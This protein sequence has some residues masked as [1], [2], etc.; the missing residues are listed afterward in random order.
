MLKTVDFYQVKAH[1]HPCTPPPPIIK[2]KGRKYISLI[3]NSLKHLPEGCWKFSQA[4][5]C[6]DVIAV[7]R[8]EKENSIL[9]ENRKSR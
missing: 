7:R 9:C 8:E 3:G 1:H 2:F 6:G 4:D 5:N